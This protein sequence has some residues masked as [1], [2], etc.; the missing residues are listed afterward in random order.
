MSIVDANKD[1]LKSVSGCLV[2]VL[3]KQP[4]AAGSCR[5]VFC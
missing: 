3:K 2:L 1:S 4:Y 5:L